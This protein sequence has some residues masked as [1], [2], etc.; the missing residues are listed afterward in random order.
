M[1]DYG[2][3]IKETRKLRGLTQQEV[4]DAAGMSVMTIRRYES[5]ERTPNIASLRKIA[6][7]MGCSVV[8]LIPMTGDVLDSVYS[9]LTEDEQKEV[10]EKTSSLLMSSQ[11]AN[12]VLDA[13]V[14]S[15]SATMPIMLSDLN[16]LGIK[17]V[18]EY[19]VDIAQNPK[20]QK[21]DED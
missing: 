6:E 17:K 5:G 13:L 19:M 20:Y 3:H 8:N 1:S 7:A 14:K 16:D 2:S 9:Q 21:K 4:A 10:D 18:L 11:R 15:V 12:E